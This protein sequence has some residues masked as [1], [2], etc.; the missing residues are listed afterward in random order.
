MWSNTRSTY[1][2]AFTSNS[3]SETSFD[4][5]GRPTGLLPDM[6][7]AAIITAW[8]ECRSFLTAQTT[9]VGK[10]SVKEDVDNSTFQQPVTLSQEALSE[11]LAQEMKAFAGGSPSRS[12]GVHPRR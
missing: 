4:A 8:D 2:N 7:H 1:S 5:N 6:Q 12:R 10:N 11:C 9:V 3:C